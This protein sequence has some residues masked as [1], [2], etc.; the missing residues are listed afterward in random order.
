MVSGEEKKRKALPEMITGEKPEMV[1]GVI[2][3]MVSAIIDK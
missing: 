1:S 3:E 2:P